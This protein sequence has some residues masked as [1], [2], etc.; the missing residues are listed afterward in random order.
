[1]EFE[2]TFRWS[3]CDEEVSKGVP[4]GFRIHRT[5]YGSLILRKLHLL[6]EFSFSRF[7]SE[8]RVL[9]WDAVVAFQVCSLVMS[10]SRLHTGGH[11]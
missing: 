9:K 8:V 1:M 3:N 6:C 4:A 11:D 7:V 2:P 5:Y 10:R